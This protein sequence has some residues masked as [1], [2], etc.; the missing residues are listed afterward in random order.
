M[1]KEIIK[2]APEKKFSLPKMPEG[3][4]K[5]LST[6][7][8][9]VVFVASPPAYFGMKSYNSKPNENWYEKSKRATLSVIGSGLVCLLGSGL[10]DNAVKN[11][12]ENSTI[13]GSE[14]RV[15]YDFGNITFSQKCNVATK[16]T[17]LFMK[18]FMPIARVMYNH[19]HY[20][21]ETSKKWTSFEGTVTRDGINYKVE[22]T[23]PLTTNVTAIT[24]RD[25]SKHT[26]TISLLCPTRKNIEQ[27]YGLDKKVENN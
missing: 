11:V 5:D 7:A 19:G 17:P 16:E 14:Q 1:S 24:A 27:V 22:G 18:T 4:R 26:E 8:R 2:T 23:M 12:G 15:N 9:S 10:C 3:L 25:L 20:A 21:Y 6:F 13:K